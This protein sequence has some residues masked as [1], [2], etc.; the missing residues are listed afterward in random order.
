MELHGI[1]DGRVSHQAVRRT[2]MSIAGEAV[3]RDDISAHL[4]P[5]E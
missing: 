3:R 4:P 1:Q 2:S 5:I